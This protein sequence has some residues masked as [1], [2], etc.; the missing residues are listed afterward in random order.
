M[1][2]NSKQRAMRVRVLTL[3]STFIRSVLLNPIFAM[4]LEI[5]VSCID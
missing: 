5:G 1:R 3:G 2:K 4:Q